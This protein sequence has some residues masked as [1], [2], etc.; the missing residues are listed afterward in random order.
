[1]SFDEFLAIIQKHFG[2]LFDTLGGRVSYSR[3]WDATYE[4]YS[5][6]IDTPSFRVLFKKEEGGF[7]I[8]LGPPDA[9]FDDDKD[10]WSEG[11]WV[12]VHSL[13]RYVTGKDADW[14]NLE[15]KPYPEQVAGVFSTTAQ[16]VAS[17]AERFREMF[18]SPKALSEWK[19][20]FDTYLRNRVA[21]TPDAKTD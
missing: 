2:F 11:H 9:D 6:G 13:V 8:F 21:D 20:S 12:N 15:T 1:M 18:A 5:V 14:S 16:S 10:W 17:L 7:P 19:P 4:S 3:V